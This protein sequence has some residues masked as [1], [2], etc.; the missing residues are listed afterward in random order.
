MLQ[1]TVNFPK[2]E[3]NQRLKRHLA[4]A[5]QNSTKERQISLGLLFTVVKIAKQSVIGDILCLRND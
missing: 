4:A 3:R 2:D 5:S 1:T